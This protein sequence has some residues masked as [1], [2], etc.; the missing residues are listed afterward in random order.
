MES[1]V[2]TKSKKRNKLFPCFRAAASGS[3]VG[4]G[5]PEEQVFPFMTVRDNVLPV[6]RGDEDSS[7]WKKKGGR[8][9][10]SRAIRAVIFG[11]SLA[12]KIAKRKAKHYQ[13]SK[14]SQRHLAPSWFSSRSRSGSDLNYRNYST[15]SSEPFSSPSFYSSSPSSTEK[16]DSS[17]RL[18]PTASNRLY[19]QINFRKIFSGWFVLLVC[20]LSL[21]L[22]GKTGAIIC[23]SVWLLCLYR[24]RFRFRSPDDKASTVAMS[25]GE[26]NDIEIMEEFLKRDRLAARNSTLRID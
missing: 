18:Y 16:S 23:T 3:P 12:K 25:S 17:F 21:V 20:L 5:A 2:V 1:I 14:E 11:T 13:N 6:D 4:H 19:T 10:W 22:W 15:R 9:A 26:Y 24:W 7:R 8:G